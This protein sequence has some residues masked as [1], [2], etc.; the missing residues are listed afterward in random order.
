MRVAVFVAQFHALTGSQRGV[1]E[2]VTNF[3]PEVCPVGVFPSDGVC[4]EE[5][6]RI[7]IE[8][9]I[10]QAPENLNLFEKALP[11][12]PMQNKAAV[13]LRELLPYN[14]K[15]ARFLRQNQIDLLH[16]SSARGTLVAGLAG[17]LAGIPI[18]WHNQSRML[19]KG[20]FRAA[21]QVLA[22]QIILVSEALRP[23][24]FGIFQRKCHVIHTGGFKV[25]DA[26]LIEAQTTKV[27]LPDDYEGDLVI[28]A[29]STITPFKGYHHLIEAARIIKQRYKKLRPVFLVIAEIPTEKSDRFVYYDYL[30]GLISQYELDNFHFLGWQS[31]PF[32]YYA[33]SDIAVM[34][35]VEREQLSIGGATVEV[36]GHESWGRVLSEAMYMGKPVVASRIAGIPEQV[37]D[38]ETGILVPPGNPEAIAEALIQL[39]DSPDLRQKMGQAGATRIRELCST[40]RIVDRVIALYRSLVK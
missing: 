28:S 26:A 16:C 24:I 3:P 35:S 21:P 19:F 20:I 18:V 22:S 12:M 37:I 33:I 25:E 39:M 32:S 5:F 38:Q 30:K 1:L 29:F 14:F 36:Q 34:P 7:G 31:N 9:H 13:L 15:V 40:E 23:D 11:R 4:A 8:T 17:R 27:K 10:V 2:L 6:R